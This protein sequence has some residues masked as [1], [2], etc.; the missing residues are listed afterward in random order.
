MATVPHGS[1]DLQIQNIRCAHHQRREKPSNESLERWTTY[2]Q[3]IYYK[4]AL[5]AHDIHPE[6]IRQLG[7]WAPAA[8]DTP[9]SRLN[10]KHIHK[11]RAAI[12]DSND[13]FL[14]LSW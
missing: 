2:S 10:E 8:G 1:Q 5:D 3:K 13:T 9:Y 14:E 11:T 4:A 7:A 12:A 6:I